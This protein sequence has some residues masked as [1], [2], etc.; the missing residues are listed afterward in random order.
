M[1][2]IQPDPSVFCRSHTG[3]LSEGVIEAP[4]LVYALGFR[5]GFILCHS[6]RKP[7]HLSFTVLV[8]GLPHCNSSYSIVQG[9]PIWG[10]SQLA[11][12]VPS[13]YT[14]SNQGNDH[15]VDPLAQQTYYEPS[16]AGAPFI[17]W[18]PYAPILT[19]AM[20]TPMYQYHHFRPPS[21]N[22]TTNFLSSSP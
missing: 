22:I 6:H 4:H 8:R 2:I 18:P 13:N 20:M 19:G 9:A 3:E 10:F 12:C 7:Y 16:L 5:G 15:R 14:I 11:K 21:I 17:T 1:R